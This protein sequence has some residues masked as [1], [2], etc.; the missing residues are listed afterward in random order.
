TY[1]LHPPVDGSGIGAIET[2]LFSTRTGYCQQF[3]GSYAVLAR[4]IGL[5]TRLAVGFT[6]GRRIGPHRYQ[7]TDAD[8]HTWPEVW[9]PRYG[10]VPFEPT[11]GVP[12]A[13][14]AIPGA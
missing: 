8:V 3:A 11:K 4:S 14:F 1:S 12:G 2:F 9:F 6:T 13:G 5:P 7:V 10:W